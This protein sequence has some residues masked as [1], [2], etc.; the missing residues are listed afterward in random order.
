MIVNVG[1]L[2]RLINVGLGSLGFGVEQVVHDSVVEQHC[3]LWHHANV[4]AD[5]VK[6]QVFEI[7][8]IDGDGAA[9]NVVE[10]EEKFQ[11]RR[12]ATTGLAYDCRLR[13]RGNSEADA[14]DNRLS[15]VAFVGEIDIMEGN[16]SSWRG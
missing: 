1:R 12:F 3:V 14:V 13:A 9:R 11:A 7:L 4:A 2:A 5:A 10:T 16:F 8:T 6:L 15:Y